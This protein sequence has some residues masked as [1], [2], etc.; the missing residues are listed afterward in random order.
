[1]ILASPRRK[2]FETTEGMNR[3]KESTNLLD[4]LNHGTHGGASRQ[5]RGGEAD[6]W[7]LRRLSDLAA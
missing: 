7:R 2:K 6:K 4:N 1:M 5:L 3:V